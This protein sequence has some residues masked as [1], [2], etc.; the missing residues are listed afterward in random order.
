VGTPGPHPAA[1]AATSEEARASRPQLGWDLIRD[2]APAVER[3]VAALAAGGR[4]ATEFIRGGVLLG[5]DAYTRRDWELNTLFL[6]RDAY[7]FAAPAAA[8]GLPD[9]RGSAQGIPAY[10]RAMEGFHET[11]ADFAIGLDRIEVVDGSRVLA[12]MHW[13]ARGRASGLPLDHRAADEF[14]FRDG[15]VVRQTSWLYATDAERR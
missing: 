8:R 9:G 15:L 1:I 6:D 14:E 2:P 10:V 3:T 11:W 13:T 7:T 12:V 4:E 5:Y